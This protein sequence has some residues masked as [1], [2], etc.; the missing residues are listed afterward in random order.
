MRSYP[1]G[2]VVGVL[3]NAAALAAVLLLGTACGG[4][5]ASA[6]PSPEPASS[7]AASSPSPTDEPSED[8]TSTVEPATG[9]LLKIPQATARVPEGWSISKP[10]IVPEQVDAGN[11]QYSYSAIT[12]TTYADVPWN[13]PF[14][15]GRGLVEIAELT[16]ELAELRDWERTVGLDEL[17]P[18]IVMRRSF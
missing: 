11:H 17:G 5:D 8:P 9:P 15:A 7:S 1:H 12:L 2:K 4:D 13:A 3:K 14:Y 16:P 6:D 10:R 18:R